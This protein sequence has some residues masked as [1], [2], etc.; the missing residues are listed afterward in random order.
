MGKCSGRPFEHEA[1]IGFDPQIVH[2][3]GGEPGQRR[4]TTL[5]VPHGLGKRQRLANVAQFEQ[6]ERI[7]ARQ[8][9]PLQFDPAILAAACRTQR[10]TDLLASGHCVGQAGE[11][12]PIGRL[13]ADDAE[14]LMEQ[15]AGRAAGQ[16]RGSVVGIDDARHRSARAT[17]RNDEQRI[18]HALE[19]VRAVFDRRAPG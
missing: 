3:I 16:R 1:T 4:K 12:G 2:A 11:V 17:G 5:V 15:L 10:Q 13:G 19:E 8:R 9:A 7:V 6:V 14:G 18:E